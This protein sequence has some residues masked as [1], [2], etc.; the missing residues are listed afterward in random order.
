M[1]DNEYNMYSDCFKIRSFFL[2]K[3]G[4][5]FIENLG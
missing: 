4:F 1:V 3:L 2:F 5:D